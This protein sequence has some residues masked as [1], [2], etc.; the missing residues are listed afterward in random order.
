MRVSRPDS[1]PLVLLEEAAASDTVRFN[2]GGGAMS[3]ESYPNRAAVR[4]SNN[5]GSSVTRTSW[6]CARIRAGGAMG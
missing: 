1:A 4:Y 6:L 5:N 2:D 3:A